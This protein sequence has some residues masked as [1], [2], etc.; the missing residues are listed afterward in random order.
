MN[1]RFSDD[2]NI[3]NKQWNDYSPRLAWMYKSRYIISLFVIFGILFHFRKET[4]TTLIFIISTFIIALMVKD[5]PFI[6]P[7]P[8]FW[9]IF[10]AILIQ[11]ILITLA[12]CLVDRKVILDYIVDL[13]PGKSG[14]FSVNRDYSQKCTIYDRENP[15][16]PFHN[17]KPVIFDI[18][19]PAHFFGWIFHSMI[20]RDYTICWTLSICFEICEVLLRQWFPNFHECWWD[21]IILDILICNGLGIYIGMKFVQFL[22]KVSWDK[23]KIQEVHGKELIFRVLNQFAPR[24]FRQFHWRPLYSLK[25]YCCFIY[26]ILIDLLLEIDIFGLKLVLPM[27]PDN[28]IVISHMFFHLIVSVPSV[29]EF[30]LF[31]IGEKETIGSFGFLCSLLPLVELIFIIHCGKGFFENPIPLETKI[32]FFIIVGFVVGFPI[33]WFPF[34]KKRFIKEKSD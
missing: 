26:V 1:E 32:L 17:V 28:T 8:F 33:I 12:L 20:I 23:R 27:S 21:S 10:Q 5:G 13:T 11:V 16:D 18:F 3:A 24:S 29:Y 34:L 6:R 15:L 25:R 22:S 9:R 19:I 30:Y 7:H 31:T 14:N 2:T 4:N